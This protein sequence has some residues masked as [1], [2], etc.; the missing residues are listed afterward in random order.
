VRRER[1]MWRF[2]RE[3]AE[4]SYEVSGNAIFLFANEKRKLLGKLKREE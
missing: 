1:W 4:N 2:K 3:E